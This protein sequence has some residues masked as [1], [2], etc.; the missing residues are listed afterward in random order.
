MIIDNPE[1]QDPVV[2]PAPRAP[3]NLSYAPPEDDEEVPAYPYPQEDGPTY[4]DE[5]SQ[6]QPQPQPQAQP[7]PKAY[8]RHPPPPTRTPQSTSSEDSYVR[9]PHKLVAYLIPFPKPQLKNVPRE[10]VPDRFLVYTPPPPPLTKPAD[11]EKEAKRHLLQRKWQA[12]VREAKTS[13]AKAASWKGVKSRATR[14]IDWAIG[15]TTTS[16]L[17]FLNRMGDDDKGLKKGKDKGKD[18]AAVEDDATG[19]PRAQEDEHGPPADGA[20][21][22]D[23]LGSQSN[24]WRGER[25]AD[26]EETA[27]GGLDGARARLSD[28]VPTTRP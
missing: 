9:D 12:E 24:V 3:E 22:G 23:G 18:K 27:A 16:G 17:D 20:L 10:D 5:K 2:E 1:K 11:G 25:E 21:A 4:P 7:Q 28:D 19:A 13:T 14:G 6:L 8:A 15:R 26:S